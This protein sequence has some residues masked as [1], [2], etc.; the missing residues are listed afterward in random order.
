NS[1]GTTLGS[2]LSFTTPVAPTVAT[3]AATPITATT[4]TLNGTANPNGNTT[5]GWFRYSSTD[6]GTCND[7]FG[8]RA[9]G[10]GGSGLGSGVAFVN[11]SQALTALTPGTTYYFCAIAQSSIGTSL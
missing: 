4:A 3:F 2:L 8:T 6:P 10:S 11:F 9:P 5:T 7:T 1:V